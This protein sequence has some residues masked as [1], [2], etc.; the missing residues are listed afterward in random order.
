M[1]HSKIIS[2]FKFLD[3]Y[4]KKDYQTYFGR[5]QESSSLFDLYKDSSIMILHG[6]SGS[7]KTS[8]IYCGLLN[9]IRED[10]KVISIRR[11]D[12]IIE[13]IKKTLFIY[14]GGEN[15]TSD[16][17]SKLLDDFFSSHA[18][19]NRILGFIE[20]IEGLMLNVEEEIIER[21]RNKKKVT[22]APSEQL[23]VDT[24]INAAEDDQY[25][26]I[27]Y[28]ERL[29]KFIIERKELLEKLREKNKQVTT[30]S[31]QLNHYLTNVRVKN[32]TTLFAPLV[33]FDQFEEL[34]VHG[35]KEEINRFGFF[36]KLIFDYKIPFNIIIS[37]REEY[38]GYLDQLQSY[39]PHI[40]YKKIRLAHPDKESI[41]NIIEKSFQKFNINQYKGATNEELPDIEK[42]NRIELILDQIKIKDN[43]STSYH[44][45][46]LQVYLDRLYKIDYYR[47][48]GS[49][50][51]RNEND[52][53]LPLEFKEDEIKEFGSIENVLENYIREINNKI[54]RNTD[55]KLNNKVQHKDSV[56][57]FLR[58]FRTKDDLK[59]RVPIQTVGE[60]YYII[61]NQK[62]LNKIQS[63]IWHDNN[64]EYN[65]TVSEIINELKEKGILNVSTDYA[66]LSHD[67]IAKVISNIRTEDDFR[68]LIKKD[69]I[70][71]FD[72]YEDTKNEGDLLSIQ[73]IERMNQCMSYIM[74]DDNTERL[75]RKKQ[76]LKKSIEE[77]QK[78]ELE[79]KKL[80]K[81]LKKFVYYP[82]IITCLL[83][84]LIALIYSSYNLSKELKINEL[85]VNI[86][87]IM[88]YALSDYNIDKTKSLNYILN[89]EDLLEKESKKLLYFM[90]ILS[91]QDSI[92][93]FVK[94]FKNEFYKEYHRTPLYHNSLD[95]KGRLKKIKA[96]KTRLAPSNNSLLYVFV[97]SETDSLIVKSVLYKKKN[98]PS[99]SVLF[100]AKNVLAYEPFK[101]KNRLMTLIAQ[102]D[103]NTVQLKLIDHANEN[104]TTA[105][106]GAPLINGSNKKNDSLSV[107]IEHQSQYSFLIAID[108]VVN[109]VTIDSISKNTYTIDPI[110]TLSDP[111]RKI[112]TFK[113]KK[114]YLVL[115]GKN[116]FYTNNTTI[117][118]TFLNS[119]LAEEDSFHTFQIK[120]DTTLFL[121]LQGR[122]KVF[123][124]FNKNIKDHF[125]HDK[126]INTI[127]LN[128]EGEMLISS[129]DNGANLLSK[130]NMLLKQFIGHAKPL[131]NV[132]FIDKNFIVTSSEDQTVKIW[133]IA[134]I[135][136]ASGSVTGEII[137]VQY[138]NDDKI[139]VIYNPK[140][141]TIKRLDGRVDKTVFLSINDN[142]IQEHKGEVKNSDASLDN[143][144][145]LSRISNDLLLINNK[146]KS[147]YEVIKVSPRITREIIAIDLQDSLLLTASND[148]TI[149]I[150][151]KEKGQSKYIQIP[152]M[153]HHDYT[154]NAATFSKDGHFILSGDERG[155]IKKWEFEKFEELINSRTFKDTTLME[156]SK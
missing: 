96:T 139:K 121:G 119:A 77:S 130:N 58:H 89:S 123:D 144:Y 24:S 129:Q 11:D 7:G 86:H 101:S 83:F 94:D 102:K 134:P 67:I 35:T 12:N 55:N 61:N 65:D 34:F 51:S 120:N 127:D 151:Q 56:I 46:F 114:Y 82:T 14:S 80:E 25:A 2:P 54:I 79:K 156:T 98:A 27:K 141:D 73:Q 107:Y 62:T 128:D 125:V 111:I 104:K 49:D 8:L 45:P 26:I 31:N 81:R 153:I 131:K 19:L 140:N 148:N 52:T 59:K 100:E 36:L 146:S 50:S 124:L 48:Y 22:L 138:Q 44:L 72:I 95:F 145:K 150:Y 152:S 42:Q 3:S 9:K 41:K 33:I 1:P 103:D 91:D 132:S 137:D 68:S 136:I 37:L 142:S 15:W 47:T 116:K 60:N 69:F 70:S 64:L 133:N 149:Q 16:T 87:K 147:N 20:H 74:N 109:K 105:V 30:I 117:D 115:H 66:E 21:K 90:P 29:R 23:E 78:E 92:F 18:D 43:G 122:I 32:S 76:F 154:I 110:I 40:F 143:V 135:E 118:S 106:T 155:N 17:P 113:D 126:Q 38:F 93:D 88:G 6:P 10:K 5:D 84:I 85:S 4:Q 39:I 97:L 57:K 63:D 99:N 28:K 71:S 13:A 108:K 112:K 53:L 75:E